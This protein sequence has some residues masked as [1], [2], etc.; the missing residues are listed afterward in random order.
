MEFDCLRGYRKYLMVPKATDMRGPPAP[1]PSRSNYVT[2]EG[3]A[4]LRAEL[5]ELWLRRRPAVTRA[6]AEAAAQGDRSENAEY[7]YGKKQLREIDRRVRHLRKRLELLRVVDHAPTD[8][9]R[10]YFGAWAELEDERGTAHR[11]RVVGPDEHDRQPDYI[12]VDSPLGRSLL[13][14]R[15]D[16]ELV[17]ETPDGGRRRYRVLDIAYATAKK[18]PAEAGPVTGEDHRSVSADEPS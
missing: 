16:D 1:G 8:T 15:R 14:K 3:A 18:C 2:P 7:I 17:V 10:I 6:V 5:D 4:A 9:S 12:S 13:G 11:Y